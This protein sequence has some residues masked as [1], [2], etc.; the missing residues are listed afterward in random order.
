MNVKREELRKG[1]ANIEPL[2]ETKRKRRNGTTSRPI[3]PG[4]GKL[5][6]E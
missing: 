3:K 6:S 5:C 2:P 1:N 4:T